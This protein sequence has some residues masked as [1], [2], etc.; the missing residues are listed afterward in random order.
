MTD[1][2]DIM[3]AA[4][5]RREMAELENEK[6]RRYLKQK[7]KADRA[8]HEFVDHFLH[9]HL[10]K[11]DFAA[12]RRKVLDAARHGRFEVLAMRFPASLCADGGRAINNGLSGWEETLPGKAREAYEVWSKAGRK[13]GFRFMAKI[14][15]FPH[16]MPGDVGLFV[17]WA[18][19]VAA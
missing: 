8:F 2:Q 5:L 1:T 17:S 12:M 9:D 4:D 18:P 11:Q 15:D 7:E 3:T 16:G 14:L 19:P 13:K 10:T 6:L